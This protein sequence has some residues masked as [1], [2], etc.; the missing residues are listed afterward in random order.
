MTED[1]TV[2]V[3][4]HEADGVAGD[5]LGH[6]VGDGICGECPGGEEV[7][8][9]L[10]QGPIEVQQGRFVA[11]VDIANRYTLTGLAWNDMYL[12][13]LGP[14]AESGVGLSC[15]DPKPVLSILP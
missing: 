13:L 1:T 10:G 12:L 14:S 8:V 2:F 11:R 6:V 4:C 3:G 7:R 15:C 9:G 5:G